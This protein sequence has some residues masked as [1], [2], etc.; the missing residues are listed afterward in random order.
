MATLSGNNCTI[1]TIIPMEVECKITDASS[2]TATDGIAEVQILGGT[3]PYTI[4]W[5]NGG[6]GTTIT[7]L[8]PGT[9]SA[10]VTD[11]YGDYVVTT[12]CVVGS[13][14]SIFYQ[15]DECDG[16]PTVYVSGSTYDPP[17]PNFKPIIKFNEISGC[18]EFIGPISS[19]GLPYS[20]LTISNSYTTCEVCNPPTPTPLPQGDLCL[21]SPQL[22]VQYDFETNGTDSNGNFEWINTANGLVMSYNVTNGWWEV[23]PWTNVGTGTM[24]LI[25]SPPNTQPIGDWSNMGGNPKFTWQVQTGLCGSFPLLLNLSVSQPNCEGENGSVIM[26]ASEGVPPYQYK[27]DGITPYQGSG[28]FN[29]V[30]PGSYTATVQD[31]DTPSSTTSVNF[32]IDTGVSSQVYSVQLTKTPT[33]TTTNEPQNSVTISYDYAVTVNPALPAGV[34]IS[35]NLRF[36]HTEERK[37]PID[38]TSAIFTTFIVGNVDGSP[39]TFTQSAQ[40]GTTGENCQDLYLGDITTYMS[41]SNTVSITEGST[42]TGTVTQAVDLN[43]VSPNCYCPTVGINQVSFNA[44]NLV[45]AGSNCGTLDNIKSNTI[46]ESVTR[47]GCGGQPSGESPIYVSQGTTICN[48]F[49]SQN[50]LVNSQKTCDGVD[51]LQPTF[52]Y[53]IS[54]GI[55]GGYYAYW[56]SSTQTATGQFRIAKLQTATSGPNVGLFGQVI[57][58]YTGDCNPTTGECIPL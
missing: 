20:D 24:N 33:I 17:F 5:S 6:Q 27:I 28:V 32:V 57:D 48:I 47:S 7:N 31:S 2:P 56:S 53:G 51:P 15:F 50:F 29:N 42:V 40:A 23:T 21:F 35:L 54:N 3:A 37:A 49:C 4:Q 55:E 25:Q 46:T 30:A 58:L 34:T 16:G 26:T 22:G 10:T 44:E 13:S 36:N 43:T 52:I 41:T 1:I 8:L 39:M 38:N 9:Y 14:T 19:A 18:F 12:S 45:L 11:Y